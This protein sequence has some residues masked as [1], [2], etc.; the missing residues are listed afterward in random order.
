[1]AGVGILEIL[2]ALVVVSIGVLGVAGLQLTGMKHSAGGYNRF[3]ATLFAENLAARMR[4]N[5]LAVDRGL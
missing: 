4:T 5:T 3:K 1:M 2:V